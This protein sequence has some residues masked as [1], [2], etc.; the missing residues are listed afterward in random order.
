L[1]TFFPNSFRVNSVFVISILVSDDFDHLLAHFTYPLISLNLG[2]D[3]KGNFPAN[4]KRF[5]KRFMVEASNWV[6]FGNF[7]KKLW[8]EGKELMTVGVNLEVLLLVRIYD[9]AIG[10]ILLEEELRDVVKMLFEHFR[11][12]IVFCRGLTILNRESKGKIYVLVIL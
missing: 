2:H 9:L 8:H 1:K 12:F 6:Y 10:L 3:F 4:L 11:W 5:L 7:F